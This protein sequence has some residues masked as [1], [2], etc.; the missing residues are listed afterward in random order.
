ML[1]PP[2]RAFPLLVRACCGLLLVMGI[3]TAASLA[4][5]PAPSGD[6]KHEAP[7]T[8][9]RRFD[10][11]TDGVTSVSFSPD[12]RRAVSASADKTVRYWQLPGDEVK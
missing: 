1:P 10:G 6:K 12:G 7:A 2:K 9:I 8:E 4:P 5:A 11:H 3:S